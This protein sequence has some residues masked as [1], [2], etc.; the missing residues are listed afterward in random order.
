MIIHWESIVIALRQELSEYGALLI[1]FEDQQ[2]ALFER[3][4][5]AVLAH[6]TSIES[7][8]HSLAECRQNREKIVA[9]FALEHSRPANSTLR[10]LLPLVAA[11]AQPLLEALIDEINRLLHRVR[12]T[13]RHN[14]TLLSRA[15]E[16]H[17]E[18]LQILRP[19]TFIKT[20]SPAGRVS[21]ASDPSAG[22]LRVAG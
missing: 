10:S 4:A 16:V 9:A 12:R 11:E 3:D 21:V 8:A 20:Y 5:D 7:Q 19:H 15:V 1:L 22:S 18:T 2:R 14:H 17:Q 6:A 13:S